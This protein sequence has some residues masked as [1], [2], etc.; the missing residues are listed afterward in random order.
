MGFTTPPYAQQS[1]TSLT[2]PRHHEVNHDSRLIYIVAVN[3]NYIYIYVVVVV[4][5]VNIG[6]L[7]I[8]GWLTRPIS[9][10]LFPGYL[11]NPG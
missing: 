10:P 7:F 5:V 11:A 8:S 1:Y 9:S 6:A 3:S 2:L 4:V